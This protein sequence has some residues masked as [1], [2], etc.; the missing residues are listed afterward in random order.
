MSKKIYS[1]V[2]LIW[3]SKEKY[4]KNDTT[5]NNINYGKK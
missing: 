5:I 2:Y 1:S 3:F 4:G